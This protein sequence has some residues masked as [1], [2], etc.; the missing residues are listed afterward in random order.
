MQPMNEFIQAN[1]KITNEFF[2]E[3]VNVSD[4]LHWDSMTNLAAVRFQELRELHSFC[5]ENIE[6]FAKYFMENKFESTAMDV[7]VLVAELDDSYEHEKEV[8]NYNACYVEYV[9]KLEQNEMKKRDQSRK[10]LSKQTTWRATKPQGE[11][12]SPFQQG[13]MSHQGKR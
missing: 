12:G 10:M 3:Y 1:Q 8:P 13:H 2:D 9:L 6:K 4:D 5:K 7:V 11:V